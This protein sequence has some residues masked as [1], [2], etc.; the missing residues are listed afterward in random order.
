[1]EEGTRL[2]TDKTGQQPLLHGNSRR[3]YEEFASPGW[4]GGG[5]GAVTDLS[6][7]GDKDPVQVA[8]MK[9][10]RERDEKE[11]KAEKRAV[12]KLKA[13]AEIETRF[14]PV[15]SSTSSRRPTVS[16]GPLSVVNR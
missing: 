13:K 10:E 15:P 2:E 11:E 9:R 8:K 16:G 1:M 12:V 4:R 6:K 7:H 3:Y 14:P 5:G